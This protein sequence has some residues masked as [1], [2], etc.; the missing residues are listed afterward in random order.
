M[1]GLGIGVARRPSSGGIAVPIIATGGTITY[2]GGRTIHT[3]TS[4]GTFNVTS[5]PSGATVEA[6]VV[7]GGGGGGM[8]AGGGG[9]AGGVLYNAT[10]SI[11]VTAYTV[12]VGSG[13]SPATNNQTQ[14][15]SGNNSV[16]DTLTSIGGGAGGVQGKNPLN[17]G[18]GGGMAYDN[19]TQSTGTAGQG[20]NGGIWNAPRGGGGGGGKGA[21][22]GLGSVGEVAGNGGIG[23][24]Y[25]VNGTPTYF[26]G[27]GAGGGSGDSGIG[28]VG[29]GGNSNTAG[30]PNTGG[31]GG[32]GYLT[33][34][35]AK[36]G[37]SG[38]VIISYPT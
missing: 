22:G 28:G 23:Q 31:G 6:L 13:G 14:G 2:S 27:G 12:T 19:T 18:S 9:G 25:S 15:T 3:F 10:K 30:T 17:G 8:Y 16:F 1:I 4:S 26:G 24:Q 37:G 21:V 11:A 29:G 20:N 36:A 38:I 35:Q 34:G 5:A 33:H 7:A 32:G